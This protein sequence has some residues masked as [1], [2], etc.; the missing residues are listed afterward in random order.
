M[1]RALNFLY[2]SNLT[3]SGLL[4]FSAIFCLPK[5]LWEIRNFFVFGATSGYYW[6]EI[7]G[8]SKFI[9][10][11]LA[12]GVI[13][14]TW[15]GRRTDRAVKLAKPP[16]FRPQYEIQQRDKYIGLSRVQG[17]VVVV[18][19]HRDQSFCRPLDHLV[20][21]IVQDR[22]RNSTFTF[23]FDDP[24]FSTLQFHV[25]TRHAADVSAKIDYALR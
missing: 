9:W 24:N 17:K 20:N 19:M 1:Q 2:R 3:I 14:A 5:Y 21:Y 23:V 25:P 6:K 4:M 18:D 15:N 7:V 11:A 13:I 8:W 22:G 10:P 12:Y 16:G